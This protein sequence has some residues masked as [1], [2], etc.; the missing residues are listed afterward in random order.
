ML[1][2]S[3]SDINVSTKKHYLDLRF[4]K[5]RQLTVTQ[6][7]KKNSNYKRELDSP[8]FFDSTVLS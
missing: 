3:N 8:F 5:S 7:K 4:K 6:N 2:Y 1:K